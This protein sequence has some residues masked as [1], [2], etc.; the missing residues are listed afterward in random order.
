MSNTKL[1]VAVIGLSMGKHHLK[2]V[3]ENDAEGAAIC[4]INLEGAKRFAEKYNIAHY[5]ASYETK[6]KEKDNRPASISAVI[7]DWLLRSNRHRCTLSL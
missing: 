4:D 2:A 1:T 6:V 7:F 3:I 5:F